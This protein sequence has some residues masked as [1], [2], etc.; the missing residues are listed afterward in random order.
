[1]STIALR[2]SVLK[3][4]WLRQW[5]IPYERASEIQN[6]FCMQADLAQWV[7]RA[8]QH[9]RMSRPGD[10]IGV[11]VSGGADSVALLRIFEELA[12]QLG[13]RLSVLH[14][15][16]QL[17][18]MESDADEQFVTAL[19]AKHGLGSVAKREDVAAAARAKGWNLEDAARRLRY[20]FFRSTVEE[21]QLA[22]VA[23]AHTA[24]DQAETVLSRLVRGTGPGG[25][26]AIYPVKG[27]V[28][29]P[30]LGV[31][32]SELRKYLER[33]GQPWREDVSN[34]DLLRL[35]ARLRHQLLPILE[36]ELQPA[37][38]PHLCRLARLAREDEAFWMALVRERLRVLVRREGHRLGI[39][40]ADVAAPLAWIGIEQAGEAQLALAQRLVRG[41]IGELRGD[42]RRLTAQHVE[43]VLHLAATSASGHSVELPGVVVERNFDWLWFELAEHG[44]LPKP[45]ASK[46]GAAAN[47]GFV[48]AVELGPAGEETVVG[49]P[50]IRRRFCLKVIDWPALER[51]TS[52]EGA[53]DRDLLRSPL[54]LRNWR[55]GD[56]FQ[57]KGCRHVLKLKQLLREKSI[58]VR[59][60]RGWPVLTSAG[61]LAWARGFPAA[62]QFAARKNTRAGVLIVEEEM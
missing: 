56:S 14:F 1:M 31:R 58:A 16:H 13:I 20:A 11:A 39:R 27:H 29:R 35:R 22:R 47:A 42:C 19:A 4:V 40:S 38:V 50:E 34:L 26:A 54:M 2:R 51:E 7:V 43:Q 32:R 21:R 36:R 45:R 53:L 33:I 48:R 52:V 12:E 59:E 9:H 18:G 24:D 37:I 57:P 17:R 5:L 44:T 62:A 60:R 25:L 41:M 3:F 46:E 23:V 10:R 49:I 61:A 8:I 15:N 30:L 6:K 55:P 28:V